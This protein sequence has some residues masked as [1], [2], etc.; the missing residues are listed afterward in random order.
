MVFIFINDFSL[1]FFH[2]KN[3]KMFEI[4]TYLED[5]K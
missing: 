1:T 4:V 2:Y 5:L 3:L